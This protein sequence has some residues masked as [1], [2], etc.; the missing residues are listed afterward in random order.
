MAKNWTKALLSLAVTGAAIGGAIAYKKYTD[1]L[2]DEFDDAFEDE[3][4][5][6]DADLEDTS[7]RGYVTLNIHHDEPSES[8]ASAE[9][10]EDADTVSSEDEGETATEPE[11]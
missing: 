10:A 3:D 1:S 11:V 9:K 6:L 4:Y 7:N 5:D 2:E 8:D